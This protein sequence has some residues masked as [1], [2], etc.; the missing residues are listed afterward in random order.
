MPAPP[1]SHSIVNE[2]SKLLIRRAPAS[3][4]LA[5]T[6][7]FTVKVRGS[8]IGAGLR[9]IPPKVT[10]RDLSTPATATKNS[11]RVCVSVKKA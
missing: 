8:S 5:F 2:R 9:A 6:V 4:P 11:P 1:Y 10:F 3:T 7:K